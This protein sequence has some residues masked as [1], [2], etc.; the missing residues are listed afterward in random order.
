MRMHRSNRKLKKMTFFWKYFIRKSI[1]NLNEIYEYLADLYLRKDFAKK[2]ISLNYKASKRH[3]V[4]LVLKTIKTEDKVIFDIGSGKGAVLH[5]MQNYNF[6]KIYGVE[7]DRGLFR[8]SIQNL[9]EFRDGRTEIFNINVFDTPD[10]VFDSVDIF[11]LFNPFGE[12]QI[13]DLAKRLIESQCRV[14]RAIDIIYT[15]P[16]HTECFSSIDNI[17]LIKN[18]TFFVSNLPTHHYQTPDK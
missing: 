10:S 12:R 7:H 17:K 3:E 8:T 16:L 2:N 6:R 1:F 9:S 15:N 13:R 18:H 4:K 14:M 11:Y 5:L